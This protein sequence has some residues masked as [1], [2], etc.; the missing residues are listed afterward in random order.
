MQFDCCCSNFGIEVIEGFTTGRFT[1]GILVI[2]VELFS[3][4]AQLKRNAENITITICLKYGFIICLNYIDGFKQI[5][6]LNNLL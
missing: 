1:T 2:G 6:T 5:V 4:A 3:S